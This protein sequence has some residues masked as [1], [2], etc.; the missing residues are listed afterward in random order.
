MLDIYRAS[1]GS[2]KTYRL[3]L[4][5]I[6]LLIGETDEHGR[7]RLRQSLH[8]G[9]SSILA[10]TFTNKATEEMKRRIMH[11]LSILAE[12]GGHRA[13]ESGYLEALR[14]EFL[15][16]A[17]AS[18]A[19]TAIVKSARTALEQILYNYSAFRISTIDSFFQNILRTFAREAELT[20]NYELEI[21]PSEAYNTA[22]DDTLAELDT[23]PQRQTKFLRKWLQQYMES[24]FADGKNVNIFNRSSNAYGEF[25]QFF[26][27]LDNETFSP[28]RQ[29]MLQYLSDTDNIEALRQA[30]SDRCKS[31]ADERVEV[32]RQAV[33]AIREYDSSFESFNGIGNT[34]IN[35]NVTSGIA[36]Y[37]KPGNLNEMSETLKKLE[38]PESAY[39]VSC[40]KKK[41]FSRDPHLEDLLYKAYLTLG[42]IPRQTLY[43]KILSNIHILG[44][45]GHVYA[46]LEQY[47]KENNTIF[48][49]ET[50]DILQAI[51][52]DAEAPFIY[53]RMGSRLHHY[54]IDEF[55]DT[56]RLQWKNLA[57]LL[58]EG[59]GSGHQ[60]L[61][62][63]DEKQCIYRFRNSDP[64]LLRTEVEREFPSDSEGSTPTADTN[65]RSAP[66]VVQFN[67]MIFDNMARQCGLAEDYANVRQELRPGSRQAEG[68]GEV[69]QFLIKDKSEYHEAALINLENHVVRQMRDERYRPSDI[70]VLTRTKSEAAEVIDRLSNLSEILSGDPT[71]PR[72]RV[73]SDDAWFIN[74]SPSVKLIVSILRILALAPL[75]PEEIDSASKHHNMSPAEF[76]EWINR[77]QYSL[78]SGAT[79]AEAIHRAVTGDGLPSS[80]DISR[81][82]ASALSLPD[83][84]RRIVADYLADSPAS[85]QIFILSFIDLVTEFA[86]RRSN[87]LLSFIRWWDSEGVKKVL[88]S[89]ED[90]S[91][92]RV[93]TIHKSKGLEFKCVHVPFADWR[94]AEFKDNEWFACPRELHDDFP[95]LSL[96]DVLPL[97]PEKYLAGT[98]LAEYYKDRVAES[99]S[100]SVNIAYVA[101]TRAVHELIVSFNTGRNTKTSDDAGTMAQA[102]LAAI[103]SCP[104]LTPDSNVENEES[105]VRKWSYGTPL[106]QCEIA[107]QES[108]RKTVNL[109][110]PTATIEMPA[111]VSSTHRELWDATVTE[112]EVDAQTVGSLRLSEGHDDT[113]GHEADPDNLAQ[114]NGIVMHW[115]MSQIITSD[116]LPAAVKRLKD[117]SE[118][119]DATVNSIAEHISRAISDERVAQWYAPGNKVAVERVIYD[120]DNRG[121]PVKLRA[122]RVVHM[123][124]GATH[125]IDYKFGNIDDASYHSQV[126]NYCRVIHQIDP[127]AAVSGYLWYVNTGIIR[128]VC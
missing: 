50:N 126:R 10:V 64:S 11:E 76:A 87:D 55:Q 17:P 48:L 108:R 26:Q 40:R 4:Y 25:V 30:L 28:Y 117:N 124:D 23:Q 120:S 46:H 16:D 107:S 90:S 127:S 6:R 57:P 15:P 61:I 70:C 7:R 14:T 34:V 1:A 66:H 53:E 22:V 109:L 51:I 79:P 78:N 8:D 105:D 63:G 100:D 112:N 125:I 5:Y 111:N 80:L 73:V 82:Y 3:A 118:L 35:K 2:G 13:T 12:I 18:E 32:C 65:W 84:V 47:R 116:D 36:K 119:D 115:L 95:T 93:M 77:Y 85:E 9:H 104:E 52:G 123:P 91:A 41:W 49:A 102:L 71:I 59:V 68:Y 106:S 39:T 38:N 37:T 21:D 88:S 42:N 86:N 33:E 60:S 75:S 56:S 43:R 58:H 24:R 99:V 101:F 81:R 45:M 97:K 74:S 69:S 29:S 62:I 19:M 110:A 31:I 122:D 20:G 27:K 72:F 128:K 98:S 67:N 96:P 103:E 83:T 44:L 54:L 121:N 113:I 92:I 94:M 89:T 114:Y